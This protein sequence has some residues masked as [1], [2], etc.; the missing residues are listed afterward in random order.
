MIE[1]VSAYK[2]IDGSIST[3]EE[4]IEYN[5]THIFFKKKASQFIKKQRLGELNSR[6]H[7]QDKHKSWT[8]F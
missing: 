6:M 3:F 1:G 5:T 7:R 2:I 8:I 4:Q